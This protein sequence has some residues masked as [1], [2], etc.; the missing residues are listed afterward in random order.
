[1]G[2]NKK[3]GINLPI[4]TNK[5][6]AAGQ[7]SSR[8]GRTLGEKLPGC[9]GG[10]ILPFLGEALGIPKGIVSASPGLRG[11]SYPGLQAGIPLGFSSGISERHYL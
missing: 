2:W 9:V 1:M 5:R 6:S 10:S 4:G 11:T 8:S 7:I 3:D